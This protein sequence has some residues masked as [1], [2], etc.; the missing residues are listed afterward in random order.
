MPVPLGMNRGT[1]RAGT[2]MND[3]AGFLLSWRSLLGTVS[4]T[5]NREVQGR[6]RPFLSCTRPSVTSVR[7]APNGI[8]SYIH[9]RVFSEADMLQA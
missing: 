2:V 9:H 5:S 1:V 3:G 6:R 7:V 8:R 4:V